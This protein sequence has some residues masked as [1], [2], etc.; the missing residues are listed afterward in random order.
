M[1]KMF[2]LIDIGERA[3]S[4]IPNIY[5]VWETRGW[6]E[7]VLEEQFEPERTLLSLLI[8]EIGNKNKAEKENNDKSAIRIGDKESAIKIGDKESA[9]KAENKM[10]IIEFLT[11]AVSAKASEIAEYVG[12]KPSRTRDYLKELISEDIVA[13]KGANRNR[14][15]QLKR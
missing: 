4:G 1:L 11:G 2:N 12:L 13:A 9:I 14:T 6:E 5:R 10:R 15:Y 7:P 3:G 8:K